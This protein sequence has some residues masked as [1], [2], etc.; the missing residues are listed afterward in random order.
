MEIMNEYADSISDANI[1]KKASTSIAATMVKERLDSLID[2]GVSFTGRPNFVSSIE[3]GQHWNEAM[4]IL[5]GTLTDFP[6]IERM[7]IF[8]S[9]C[10]IQS[11][12]P[13]VSGNI[14]TQRGC[15]ER[16]WYALM[17][18]D[19]K[20][21]IAGVVLRT[22]KPVIAMTGVAVPI[23][24]HKNQ[25]LLGILFLLIKLDSFTEWARRF[26]GNEGEYLSIFDQKGQIVFHPYVDL[27]EKI[28]DAS[29]LLVVQKMKSGESGVE[30]FNSPYT[31]QEEVAGYRKISKYGW[32][33]MVTQP[34]KLVFKDRAKRL[35]YQSLSYSL[36]LIVQIMLFMLVFYF[37]V[38]NKES[39]KREN[40]LLQKASDSELAQ[41]TAA[42]VAEVEKQKAQ[43]LQILNDQLRKSISDLEKVN[44]IMIGRELEMIKLKQ[45]VNNCLTELGKDTKYKVA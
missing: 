1:A 16:E 41:K 32:G 29:N 28:I 9:E 22:S 2:L 35:L 31:Q 4:D 10:V 5:Q 42:A 12:L 25:N 27:S 43:E 11:M 23:V 20:P 8:D 34:A 21:H 14:G 24:S 19:L 45:E 18:K 6:I 37:L 44:K 17:K 7:V 39:S 30:I 38:K 36:L 40:V 3:E 33:V 13:L 15:K 26:E